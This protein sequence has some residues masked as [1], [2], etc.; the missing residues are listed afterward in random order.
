MCQILAYDDKPPPKGTCSES[1]DLFKFWEISYNIS[2]TVQDR[3]IF[4]CNG[5]LIGNRMWPIE[6]LTPIACET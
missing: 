5:R 2:E 1:C 3:D 4:I 6:W